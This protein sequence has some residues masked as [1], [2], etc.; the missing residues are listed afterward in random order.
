M[1]PVIHLFGQNL[2]HSYIED[3]AN[4][5]VR[6]LRREGECKVVFYGKYLEF[7]MEINSCDIYVDGN[8]VDSI[9]HF[10]LV[11]EFLENIAENVA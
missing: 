10:S 1:K 8:Y 5:I 4:A 3:T 9:C 6:E 7:Q 11:Q 2:Q